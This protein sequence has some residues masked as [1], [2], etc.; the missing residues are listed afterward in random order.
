MNCLPRS[1]APLDGE[2]LTA[3]R[4]EVEGIRDTVHAII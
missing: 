3:V 4:A 2:M 1:F